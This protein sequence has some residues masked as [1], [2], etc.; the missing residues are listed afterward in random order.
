[1]EVLFLKECGRVTLKGSP[2]RYMRRLE[3]IEKAEQEQA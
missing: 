2:P 3:E 1:M